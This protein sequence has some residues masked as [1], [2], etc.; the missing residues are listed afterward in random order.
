MTRINRITIQGFKSFADRV[1][2]PFP[3][4]FNVVCGPNGSGKSCRY[5][6]EVLLSTGE[7]KQIGDIVENILK[8][9]KNIKKLD[10]GIYSTENCD[11]IKIFGLDPFS[12]KVIKRD[13]SAF[14]KRR[15]EPKLYKITTKTGKTVITTGC[16]PVMVF[17]NKKICSKLIKHL[18]AGDFIASPRKLEIEGR[19]VKFKGKKID[20]EF[21]RFIGYLVGD[22]YIASDRIEIVNS[23][24]EILNDFEYLMKKIFNMNVKYKKKTHGK[25]VRMIYWSKQ[26][27]KFLLSLFRSKDVH[28]LTTMYK[29]IP[30]EIMISN[31]KV[32]ANFLAALFDCDATVKNDGS[33]FEYA[34]KN[35]KLADQVQLSFLRFDIVAIKRMKMKCATN[36]KNETKRK[37]F[38]ITIEG[39]EKLKKLYEN[40]PLRCEHKRR[41]LKLYAEKD[42]E[43]NPNI[44][45]IPKDVNKIIKECTKVLG[46]EYKPL[47]KKYPF[48][49][50]Y[51]ENRCCPTR[52]GVAKTVSILKKRIKK[53]EEINQKLSRNQKQLI[54]MLR[55]LKIYRHVASKEIELHEDTIN[56]H[57]ASGKTNAKPEN[58]KKLYNF[59]KSQISTK[60]E[61]AKDM[62]KLLENISH[63][64]IF[65]DRIVKIEKVSG[66]EWVYDLSIPNC[67]NFIGNGLFVHNSNVCDAI[68]FALG[69]SS[70]KIIRAEK[71]VNLIFHGTKN[72][73]PSKY[74]TVSLYLDNRDKKLPYGDEIKIT[75]KVMGNGL[76]VFRL[77]GKVVTRSKILDLLTNL[78]LS[79]HGYNIIMQG[80]INRIIEMSNLERRE[81]IDEI[82]GISEFDEKKRKAIVELEKVKM[83][84]DEIR[85]V[86]E[87]KQKLME[88][89]RKEKEDAEKSVILNNEANKIKASLVKSDMKEME[90]HLSELN[91]KIKKEMEK[92]EELNRQFENKQKELD[93]KTKKTKKIGDMIIHKARDFELARKMDKIKTEL[94]RKKDKLNMNE[95]EMMRKYSDTITRSLSE[96]GGVFGSVS[97]L[98]EIPTKYSVA[99]KVAI[100]RHMNDIIVENE[101]VAIKCI[102]F[103]KEKKIG[104]ARFLPLNKIKSRKVYLKDKKNIIDHAVNLVKFD[105]KYANA[106][107][108]ILGNSVIVEDLE[109]TKEIHESVRMITTDGDIV[110]ATGAMIGGYHGEWDREKQIIKEN[111]V[112]KKEI[113]KLENELNELK[114]LEKKEKRS[115]ESMGKDRERI[116]NSL[117]KLRKD[118][119]KLYDQ[120]VSAQNRINRLNIEKAKKDAEI[121]NLK[122]EM[123]NYKTESFYDYKPEKLRLMLK[124]VMKKINELGPVN[125]RAAEEYKIIRVEFDELKKRMD[126]L[127]SERDSILKTI[128][129][130]EKKKYEKFK[131]TLDII[132]ANFS[133]I[134]N[135]L[136][137]GEARLRLEEEGNINSGLI[138][139][140]TANHKKILNIDAMSGG[141]KTLTALGFLFAIQQYHASPFYILDE[142]DAALDKVNVKKIT[143][144]IKKY[145]RKTQF[146]VI[147]HNDLTIREADNVFGVSMEN[148]VSKIFSIKMPGEAKSE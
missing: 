82:S 88:K 53:I 4:G 26:I 54:G 89:L 98:I 7:V 141:E 115:I 61:K 74:C 102:T 95:R 65:W 84:I 131:E 79:P 78:H 62:I 41:R 8:R 101:D 132:N 31:K 75:R 9:S 52:E 34:T 35:E 124:D 86:T 44:D 39:K 37:Y 22:G 45:L 42:S 21:A 103:L 73:K 68:M 66:E 87:E 85:I 100:G 80:D 112:L 25:A 136:M 60:L 118:V 76:S 6:T 104:R 148:G 71:L 147:T 3:H 146:I 83:H 107:N 17:D 133:R 46:I 114:E 119:D 57:W 10:D 47:R 134:Y 130:I 40:I 38:Y 106:V 43:L 144:F 137:N 145:S 135:D 56:S 122:M 13:I 33:V 143:E 96:I 125:M 117:E 116:E 72:R 109:K 36:T 111:Q 123:E 49:A 127:T 1:S 113:E 18:K 19:A 140:A 91:N 30:P 16:H 90:S 126:T 20:E 27:P 58:L 138:I 110:E 48:F 14:I 28:K 29:N 129:E 15:G 128:D 97:Q 63:S 12:M 139:E 81:I 5:D 70:A 94:I 50:A 32:L 67:H 55:E 105:S 99:L 51:M 93:E 142:V 77:D 120:R 64:D 59:V 2:I 24:K 11:N 92:F 23:D 69:I 121:E 108:Y